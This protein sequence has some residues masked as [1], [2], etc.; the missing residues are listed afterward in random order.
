MDK[1]ELKEIIQKYPIAEKDA[2]LLK[3][4][5]A[6]FYPQNKLESNLIWLAHTVGVHDNLK[7]KNYVNEQDMFNL[8]AMLEKT[9]GMAYSYAYYAVETWADLYG[10]KCSPM[11]VIAGDNGGMSATQYD[12]NHYPGINEVVWEN[13]DVQVTY[14]SIESLD[15]DKADSISSQFYMNYIFKNKSDKDI[16]IHLF[17][18]SMNGIVFEEQNTLETIR[19]GKAKSI[20]AI[21]NLHSVQNIGFTKNEELDELSFELA[22]AFSGQFFKYNEKVDS[23]VIT[24]KIN[25]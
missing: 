22:Y 24:I 20:K 11:V 10:I 21:F 16:H 7:K 14:K 19:P 13:E 15:M 3:A 23:K 12:D 25:K 4:L 5:L 2:S 9:Y 6:D 8:T 18:V 17:D 1:V